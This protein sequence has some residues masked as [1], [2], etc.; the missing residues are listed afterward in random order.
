[1][2]TGTGLAFG[3]AA[4]EAA[5]EAAEGEADGE[6]DGEAAADGEADGDGE[7]ATV[8]PGPQADASTAVTARA[9]IQSVL[10]MS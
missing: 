7:F 4:A 10:F 9:R 5:A 3:V 2:E 1:M 6:A 8:G